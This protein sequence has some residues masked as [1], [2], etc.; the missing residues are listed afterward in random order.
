MKIFSYPQIT[1]N[2]PSEVKK[3]FEIFGEDI[4]LVGGSLRDLLLGKNMKDFDFATKFLPNEVIAI[5][6]KHQIKALETGI[7]FGTVTAVIN[8]KNFEI[9]TLRKDQNHQG[10][11]CDVEFVAD[12]LLDAS[13][14]DFTINALYLDCEGN[15]YDYFGGIDDLE[16]EKVKF[17]GNANSRIEED[18]LRILR[19]FRFSC[20]YAKSLDKQ[21]LEACTKQKEN[22]KKLSRERIR[23]E[24][25]KMFATSK[26]ANLFKILAVMK[27]ENRAFNAVLC[28]CIL[29]LV[30]Q[31]SLLLLS[32]AVYQYRDPTL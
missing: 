1:K 26:T 13:R 18:F 16:K 7:K 3:L 10:R 27:K 30:I 4:R 28:V 15:I 25:I 24:F 21:G 8:H 29:V 31:R 12:Y 11:H 20:E 9:T 14:R 2:F 23:Q 19:F 5:L 6:E 32:Y 17:I 22:I